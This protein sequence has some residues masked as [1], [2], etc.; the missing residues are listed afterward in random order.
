MGDLVASSTLN[1]SK[2]KYCDIFV[3]RNASLTQQECDQEAERML[4]MP[5]HPASVQG[6]TSYTVVPND[7]IYVIQFRSGS[8][9]VDNTRYRLSQMR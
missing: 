5:V 3:S 9:A 7:G 4:R 1:L 8:S 6:E 2:S